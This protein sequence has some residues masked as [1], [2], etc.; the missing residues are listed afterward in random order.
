MPIS[1][2]DKLHKYFVQGESCHHCFKNSNYKQKK[3]FRERQKQIELSR[4]KNQFHIGQ[5]KT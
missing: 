5:V 1:K 4:K 3:R 2:I